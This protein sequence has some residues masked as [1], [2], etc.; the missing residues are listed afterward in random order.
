VIKRERVRDREKE[1]ESENKKTNLEHCPD[2]EQVCA[3]PTR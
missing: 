3:D 1:N 2:S